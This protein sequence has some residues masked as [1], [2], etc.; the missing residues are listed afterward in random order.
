MVNVLHVSPMETGSKNVLGLVKMEVRPAQ[1]FGPRE[2][3]KTLNVTVVMWDRLPMVALI[4][5]T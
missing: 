4:V 5:A 3:S 2:K 1:K